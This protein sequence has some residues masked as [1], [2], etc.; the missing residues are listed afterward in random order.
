MKKIIIAAGV[1]MVVI[2]GGWT[3]CSISGMYKMYNIPT[4][5]NEPAIKVGSKIFAS[6]LKE[7]K[8]GDFIIYNYN[9]QSRIHRLVASEGDV[10][11]IKNGAVYINSKDID[12]GLVLLHVYTVTRA[13]AEK[14][15]A[16]GSIAPE[17]ALPMPDGRYGLYLDDAVAKENG[18]GTNRLITSEKEPDKYISE[19][20]IQPWNK[21]NFGP[22]T[23]P[24]NKVFVMGDNRD[25]SEDSRYLGCID[26]SNIIATV[27]K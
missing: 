23:I 24:A 7:A 17:D 5:A 3:F 12:K 19:T 25:N 18:L 15:S 1:I 11:E 21:D 13:E 22:Y 8:N 27:L 6:N 10:L 9:G 20:F 16:K 4:A 2:A 14:L 26:K